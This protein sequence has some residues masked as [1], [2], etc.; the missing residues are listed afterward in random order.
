MDKKQIE[1]LFLAIDVLI[2]ERINNQNDSFEQFAWRREK[3]VK[4]VSLAMKIHGENQTQ[5]T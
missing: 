5:S 4:Q 2:G 1:D 3:I